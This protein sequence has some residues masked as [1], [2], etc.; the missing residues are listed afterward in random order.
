MAQQLWFLRHGEA[1]PHDARPD[2]D[3]RLTPRGE[4]QSR[5]AGRAIAR[6]ELPV[7]LV[8]ASP[9]VRARDT[10]ALACE[11]LEAVE[12]AEHRALADGFD[13]DEALALAAAGAGDRRVLVVGHNPSFEQVLFDL[14]GARVEL[15][16]GALAGVR[17]KGG[18]AHELIALLQPRALERIAGA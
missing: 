18:G 11:A 6:L 9:K 14:T 16:K 13:A 8:F 1:E 5:A 10:A 4:Q 7:H 15:R 3:R 2:A 17:V 12:P